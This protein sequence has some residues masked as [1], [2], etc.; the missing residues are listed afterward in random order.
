M[1]AMS[2]VLVLVLVTACLL[3]PARPAGAQAPAVPAG[4]VAVTTMETPVYARAARL[5]TPLRVLPAGTRTRVVTTNGGWVQIAFDDPQWGERFGWVEERQ[6]RVDRSATL[7]PPSQPRPGVVPGDGR[8]TPSPPAAEPSPRSGTPPR[9]AAPLAPSGPR[10]RLVGGVTF[11]QMAASEAFD[12]VTGSSTVL[13]YGGGLQAVDVWKHLFVEGT[14]EYA[15]AD[16]ERVFVFQDEVFPLGIPVEVT[17]AP[18]DVV[19]GWRFATRSPIT[20]YVGGGYTSLWYQETATFAEAD[21]DVDERFDGYL[22]MG[23]VEVRASRWVHVRGEVRYRDVPDAL[24]GG[25]AEAFG[26]SSL[27]GFAFGVKVA[28]GR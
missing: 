7:P 9:A 11:M 10:V 16:G 2:R 14:F 6:L 26:E 13:H 17:M 19:A 27:G 21:D 3:V 24:T 1:N 15:Q 18:L 23:G 4:A 28:I 8:R 12:A 25:A 5:P 20:P 22:V